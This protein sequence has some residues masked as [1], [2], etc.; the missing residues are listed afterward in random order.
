[1]RTLAQLQLES[2]KVLLRLDLDVNLENGKV[3]DATRIGNSIPTIR[4]ILAKKASIV[5]IGHLGRPHGNVVSDLS[6]KLL[7]PTFE[8]LLDIK[9]IQFDAIFSQEI[10]SAVKSAKEGD[11][12]LLENLRFDPGE[13]TNDPRFAQSLASLGEVFVN[14]AFAVCHRN[15]ASVAYLPQFLPSAA[16]LR[17]EAEVLNLSKVVK[18]PERP[19]VAIIGGAKI[20]TKLP[21]IDYLSKIADFV[22]VG[23]KLPVEVKNQKM[24]EKFAENVVVGNLVR[25]GADID[26]STIEK[27][28]QIIVGAKTVVWNGPMGVFEEE[29][30]M[31]G[32]KTVAEAIV[33]SGAT[34]VIGGGETIAA[35]TKLGLTKRITWISS[36]GGAMLEFLAGRK[37]PG[38]AALE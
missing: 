27:F 17:L 20:E 26:L 22:L 13:E 30:Y 7:V 33:K 5:I 8:K 31:W 29:K 32:T 23:G 18:N 2:K 9:V 6:T 21:V 28:T 12:F 3:V 19:L 37:L 35:I 1:M 24:E 25:D 38:L 14:D 16:G 15:H 34:S 10:K 11:I 36:G 4:E